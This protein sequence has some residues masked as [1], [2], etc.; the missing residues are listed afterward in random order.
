MKKITKVKHLFITTGALLMAAGATAGDKG[1][2]LD[3]K[4]PAKCCKEDPS[5]CEIFDKSTLYKN[6]NNCFVQ[7]VALTGR[8]HGQYVSQSFEHS[9]GQ[10]FG[11]HYYDNRRFRLGAKVQFLND[12][13][14][15]TSWDIGEGAPGN[16]SNLRGEE[17]ASGDFFSRIDEM[18][19]NWK[20]KDFCIEGFY[21]EVGKKKLK[22]TREVSTSSN[23]ILTFERST[24]ANEVHN[25]AKPWG[26]AT[27]FKLAGIKHEV[28]VWGGGYENSADGFGPRWASTEGRGGV[29]YRAEKGLTDNTT[30]FFDYLYSNNNNGNVATNLNNADEAA[31]SVYNHVIAIGTESEWDLGVCDR[32]FGLVTDLIWG[33]DRLAQGGE[34]IV[35]GGAGNGNSSLAGQDTTGFVLMP[36]IDLTDRL[37][38]VTRYAYAD[39][40]RMQHSGRRAFE[41]GQGAFQS[42]P[43]LEDVHTMYIGLNYRLCGDNLK[44]MAGYEHLSADMFTRPGAVDQGSLEGD[45]WMLG[46]RTHF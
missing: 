3:D 7:K 26:V 27:G 8:Y 24:I 18:Y 4:C 21:V 38:L 39:F 6:E 13:N 32:K 16:P 5:W 31:L 25:D 37:Q 23:K 33:R 20:P 11:S 19:I 46:V 44:F 42:R 2:V 29:T 34:S 30:L 9:N 45:S 17:F 15:E 36:Y 43:L 12:F 14:F 22:I 28:G 35:G 41:T 1:L 10:S 40:A